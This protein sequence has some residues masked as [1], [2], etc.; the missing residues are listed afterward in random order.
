MQIKTSQKVGDLFT[1][2][3]E[4]LLDELSTSTDLPGSDM[5]KSVTF[6]HSIHISNT[7][8]IWLTIC[9]IPGNGAKNLIDRIYSSV[10]GFKIY[11]CKCTRSAVNRGQV[12]HKVGLK[13]Q[14][15]ILTNKVRISET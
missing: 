15:R 7:Y 11:T 4:N 13:D 12:N 10:L 1:S 9:L 2:P 14:W 5:K 8:F 3:P 6:G